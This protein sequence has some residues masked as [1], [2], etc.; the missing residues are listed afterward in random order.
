M[1]KS[2]LFLAL[3]GI[4]SAATPFAA[5]AEPWVKAIPY[6]PYVEL[7]NDTLF[8]NGFRAFMSCKQDKFEGFSAGLGFTGEC[9][10]YNT[11]Y[12]NTQGRNYAVHTWPD[13]G[14]P[15][16]VG[17]FWNFNEGAHSGFSIAPYD[18]P[19][20]T[21][22]FLPGPYDLRVNMLEANQENGSGVLIAS[23]PNLIWLQSTNNLVSNSNYGA[24]VRTVST[25]RQGS[26]MMYMNTQ[27]DIRNNPA[28]YSGFDT[29]PHFILEQNF[30]EVVDLATLS[31]IMVSANVSIPFA[32]TLP[33]GGS[34]VNANYS[35]GV[36]LRRKDNPASV[37]FLGYI[38]YS[39]IGE[40]QRLIGDQWGSPAYDGDNADVGG[41]IVPGAPARTITFD[42]R[43]LMNKAIAYANGALG[44]YVLD[45]YYLAGFGMGWETFG[46]HEVRSDI[47]G[48][49]MIGSPR[50]LFDAEVYE[51]PPN[52]PSIYN[53]WNNG[54]GWSEG[55]MRAHWVKYGCHEGRVASTTFDVKIYMNRWGNPGDA[56]SSSFYNYMPQCYNADGSRDYECAIA[57]YVFYGR[58]AGHPGHW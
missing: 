25:D 14:G 50:T 56:G 49:S 19:Q 12:V 57:H 9:T 46:Y 44:P 24:L 39:A 47:S 17:K 2:K 22:P 10:E 33:D 8:N 36:S 51:Q 30:K 55:Q 11:P 29:W 23:S 37:L 20:D 26:L 48:V 58:D 31:Q 6:G 4:L 54:L 34:N 18:F 32:N 1:Q 28:T 15:N 16:D 5:R 40:N 53:Q 13:T 45:D 43:E 7:L 35:I 41:P 27:T 21:P 42:L 3:I 38:L 52:Q